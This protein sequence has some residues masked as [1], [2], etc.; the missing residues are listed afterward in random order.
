MGRPGNV[1]TSCGKAARPAAKIRGMA[2]YPGLRRKVD[3][4]R[5]TGRLFAPIVVDQPRDGGARGRAHTIMLTAILPTPLL[6]LAYRA[7]FRLARGWWW[8]W[9]RPGR[10]AAVA[11][12]GEG[13]LL[14]VQTSYRPELDFPGGGMKRGEAALVCAVRELLEEVGIGA[15]VEA[16]APVGTVRFRHD[17]RPIELVLFAWT[18]PAPA[19]LPQPDGAEI[20]AAFYLPPCEL[21]ARHLAPGLRLYLEGLGDDAARTPAPLRC[22]SGP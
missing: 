3:L 15:P 14:V 10:A 21:L 19:P 18:A 17:H 8:L 12:W 5:Q 11:V 13:G 22:G 1:V 20:T 9:P 7:A 4:Q 16:C 2:A 6:R